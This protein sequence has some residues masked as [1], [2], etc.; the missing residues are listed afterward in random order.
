MIS[1]VVVVELL[2]NSSLFPRYRIQE[3]FASMD[4]LSQ[5]F[6]FSDFEDD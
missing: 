2:E 3:N 4:Y 5:V 1:S 6:F